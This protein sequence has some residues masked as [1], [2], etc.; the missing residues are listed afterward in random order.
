[1][2]AAA[3][4]GRVSYP[5]NPGVF[6]ACRMSKDA[7][8][9]PSL[10]FANWQALS[11]TEVLSRKQQHALRHNSFDSY[12]SLLLPTRVPCSAL[13][14][15]ERLFAEGKTKCDLGQDEDAYLLLMRVG[16]IADVIRSRRD[17]ADAQRT[18][19]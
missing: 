2:A 4:A 7:K 19:V 1:M 14:T 8:P 3:T 5:P 10:K 11:A 16:E 15:A 6:I 17:F 13:K 9:T 12:L 18:P